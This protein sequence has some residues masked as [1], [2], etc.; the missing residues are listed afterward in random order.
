MHGAALVAQPVGAFDAL[1]ARS[2][3]ALA[4]LALLVGVQRLAV[5]ELLQGHQ[6]YVALHRPNSTRRHDALGLA[7]RTEERLT[8][9]DLAVRQIRV[10]TFETEAVE[11]RKNLRLVELVLTARTEKELLKSIRVFLVCVI[12]LRGRHD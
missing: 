11:T 4:C 10:Q 12:V 6:E 8:G 1:L 3:S 5:E 7:D 2:T 9:P